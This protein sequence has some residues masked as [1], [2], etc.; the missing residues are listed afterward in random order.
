METSKKRK[1]ETPLPVVSYDTGSRT[2][3]RILKED[4]LDA[5]KRVVR[6]KLD[7]PPSAPLFLTQL[8]DGKNVD[9]E[10]SEDFE[11]F[12]ASAQLSLAV[13]VKVVVGNA[14][15]PAANQSETPVSVSTTE[16]RKRKKRRKKQNAE[17]NAE[18]TSAILTS[19]AASIPDSS[20]E[21]EIPTKKRRVSFLEPT[22]YIGDKNKTTE[23]TRKSRSIIAGT[24]ESSDNAKKSLATDSNDVQKQ[25]DDG[26]A[27]TSR[28]DKEKKKKKRDDQPEPVADDTPDAQAAEKKKRKKKK[29][30]ESVEPDAPAISEVETAVVADDAPPTKKSKKRSR[31]EVA[32]EEAIAESNAT[33]RTTK[34]TSTDNEKDVRPSKRSKKKSAEVL[35]SEDVMLPQDKAATS[36]A[37]PDDAVSPIVQTPLTTAQQES[38]DAA[39]ETKKA[40]RKKNKSSDP[41]VLA[42]DTEKNDLEKPKQT[43]TSA[44]E[45]PLAKTESTKKKSKKSKDTTEVGPSAQNTVAPALLLNP[46]EEVD[47]CTSKEAIGPGKESEATQGKE[48]GETSAKKTSKKKKDL[49]KDAE[50]GGVNQDTS[51][52]QDAAAAKQA[53]LAQVKLAMAQLVAEKTHKPP[54]VVHTDPV[55]DISVVDKSSTDKDASPATAITTLPSPL[56]NPPVPTNVACPVEDPKARNQV[57]TVNANPSHQSGTATGKPDT[58]LP[59]PAEDAPKKGRRS[60][61]GAAKAANAPLICPVCDAS[62]FHARYRCPVIKAGIRSMRKRIAELEEMPSNNSDDDR[63]CIIEELRVLI[64]KKTKKPRV[65]EVTKP[66]VSAAETESLTVPQDEVAVEEASTVEVPAPAPIPASPKGK[67]TRAS[68]TTKS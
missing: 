50:R 23:S 10:D 47:S 67:K 63:K 35:A 56:L 5:V 14:Q 22:P 58:A 27:P 28:K 48:K 2:F 60:S 12:V 44:A 25:G 46:V 39:V 7:I 24:A 29:H 36:N 65:S 57:E 18:A 31:N 61:L 53:R 13:K 41:E 33:E 30:S 20:P 66:A 68:A 17:G 38:S 43:A 9:L 64:E 19:R 37:K 59:T 54:K 15:A 21:T 4:S 45:E 34:D 52:N 1:R 32:V 40:K 62:P 55:Q 8:R 26:M 11:A 51:A 42:M 6:K 49:T 16:G 3:D